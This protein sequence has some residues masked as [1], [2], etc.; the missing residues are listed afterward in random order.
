MQ[1][2]LIWTYSLRYRTLWLFKAKGRQGIFLGSFVVRDAGFEPAA[3]DSAVQSDLFWSTRLIMNHQGSWASA[4]TYASTRQWCADKNVLTQILK[5]LTWCCVWCVGGGTCGAPW[6]AACCSSSGY[7]LQYNRNW[8]WG[9]Y[10]NHHKLEAKFKQRK[11][12]VNQ[13][14]QKFD[15]R[16][17]TAAKHRGIF[18]IL[19]EGITHTRA[20]AYRQGENSKFM[21]LLIPYSSKAREKYHDKKYL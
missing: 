3:S 1:S 6:R 18:R 5:Y 12:P 11:S 16:V 10:L 17:T 20:K 7:I 4:S 8:I 14:V 21:T 13:R 19:L 2:C 15:L 9:Y